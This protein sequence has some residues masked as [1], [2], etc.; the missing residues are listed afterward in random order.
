[1]QYLFGSEISLL[2]FRFRDYIRAQFSVEV[3]L[4]EVQDQKGKRI[5]IFVDENSPHLQAILAEK[6]QFLVQPFDK[7]YEQAS[8]TSG[9]TQSSHY[10]LKAF[11]NQSGLKLSKLKRLLQTSKLTF[12]ITFL[13][14][15]ISFFQ[16]IGYEQVILE[17]MHYP[18]NSPQYQQI[19]RYLS[20]T[21]VHLSLT[22]ITFNL[23]WWW[24]FGHTIEHHFGTVKLCQI[25]LIAALLT[26]FAQNIA[27]GPYFFGLSG[28]VYAV[29]GYVFIFDK[30]GSKHYFNLP[31][32]FSMILILGIITG[33]I[34]PIFGVEMGN[35]AHISGLIIGM[36]LAWLTLKRTAKR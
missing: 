31:A 8:W 20:H 13:C 35:T 4:R 11:L 24:L 1:M 9:D 33:F 25:F 28:V 5:D 6:E 12:F 18:E 26:G 7:K 15:I 27:S 29:L 34:S 10:S 23:V 22:H 36:L 17:W 32:G 16:F 30:F 21:F 19:W 14:L 2:A 3:E